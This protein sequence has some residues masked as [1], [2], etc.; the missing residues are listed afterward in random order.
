MR[1]KAI[2]F[3]GWKCPECGSLWDQ[4]EEHSA[5]MCCQESDEFLEEE[6]SQEEKK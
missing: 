5:E 1:K 6:S 3:Q 2:S 4:H